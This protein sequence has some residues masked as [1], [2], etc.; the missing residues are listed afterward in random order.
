MKKHWEF[1]HVHGIKLEQYSGQHA[2]QEDGRGEFQP[3][4]DHRCAC[5]TWM[6]REAHY[7]RS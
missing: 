1:I 2:H 3:P 7:F 5:A 4:G 6:A